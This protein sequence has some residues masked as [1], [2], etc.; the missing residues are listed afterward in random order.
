MESEKAED[1]L[2]LW[3]KL[4][5][6][7]GEGE[8]VAGGSAGPGDQSRAEEDSAGSG[9]PAAGR[10]GLPGAPDSINTVCAK[11]DKTCKQPEGKFVEILCPLTPADRAR[12]HG[13]Q[14]QVSTRPAFN[15]D[16]VNS[17]CRRCRHSCKQ[18]GHKLNLMLCPGFEQVDYP[19]DE[20][21]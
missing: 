20:G 16:K 1:Q 19:L 4:N 15:L 5:Q 21:R 9:R 12:R 11:C 2:G 7:Y 3:K 14:T 8:P 18:S 6:L 10:S 17:T 13:K